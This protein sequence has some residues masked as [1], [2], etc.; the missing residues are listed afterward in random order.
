MDKN[1]DD[2][3]EGDDF[4]EY[5]KQEFIYKRN[6]RLSEERACQMLKEFCIYLLFLSFLYCVCYSNLFYSSDSYYYQ[7]NMRNLFD[8]NNDLGKVLKKNLS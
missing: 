4:L 8:S 7:D 2:D 5:K 6:K 3:E 1:S